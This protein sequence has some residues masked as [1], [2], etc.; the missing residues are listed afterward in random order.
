MITS[1]LIEY[2][3]DVWK[4]KVPRLDCCVMTILVS[5]TPS[6]Q[7][8]LCFFLFFLVSFFLF[9]NHFFVLESSLVSESFFFVDHPVLV[10]E[11][12]L[13]S[14]LIFCFQNHSAATCGT[15]RTYRTHRTYCAHRAHHTAPALPKVPTVLTGK[16]FVSEIVRKLGTTRLKV[17]NCTSEIKKPD[18]KN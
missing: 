8:N 6:F 10:A 9:Q 16:Y 12:S 4:E 3:K 5:T 15:N 14:R 1:M 7:N 17:N 2:V 13:V 11:S 18:A